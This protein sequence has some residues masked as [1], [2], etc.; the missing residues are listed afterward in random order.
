M[1][2]LPGAETTGDD[3]EER[4]RRRAYEISQQ[5]DAG[6]PEENW[7][8]AERELDQFEGDGGSIALDG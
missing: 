3:R 1:T 6:S 4:I 5:E 7:Q 2:D 8:R